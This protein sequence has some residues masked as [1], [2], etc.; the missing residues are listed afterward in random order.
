MLEPRV[1]TVKITRKNKMTHSD[2]QDKSLVINNW[3]T[4]FKNEKFNVLV[5][6]SFNEWISAPWDVTGLVLF[7][8]CLFWLQKNRSAAEPR[9]ARSQS[10]F[11]EKKKSLI[12]RRPNHELSQNDR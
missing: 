6:E 4:L 11:R 5:I 10:G 8:A 1:W 9:A 7:A 3:A 2:T 12:G